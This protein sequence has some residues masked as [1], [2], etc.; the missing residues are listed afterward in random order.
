[1]GR[2]LRAT[3]TARD[4]DASRLA[5]LRLH[6]RLSLLQT[7]D[8]FDSRAPQG[9][10]QFWAACLAVDVTGTNRKHRIESTPQ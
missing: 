10:A 5:S 2:D 1:M 9:P 7:R 6:L 4:Y 3:A 8:C